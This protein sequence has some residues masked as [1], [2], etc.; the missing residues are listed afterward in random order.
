MSSRSPLHSM[1]Q[2]LYDHGHS[3]RPC[4]MC[5]LVIRTQ[6]APKSPT[7]QLRAICP[8][9]HALL[10]SLTGEARNSTTVTPNV[11]CTTNH[12]PSTQSHLPTS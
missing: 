6:P 4:S 12:T 8:C 10:R 7:D 3:K 5:P 2:L 11:P 1:T 9:L